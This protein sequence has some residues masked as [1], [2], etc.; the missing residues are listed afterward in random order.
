MHTLIIGNGIAGITT[1]LEIRKNSSSPITIISSESPLFFSRPAL[2]YVFMGISSLSDITPYAHDFFKKKNITLLQDEVISISALDQTV[3]CKNSNSISFDHLV[4]A[5]GS[6][7]IKPNWPGIDLDGVHYFY[8]LTDLLKLSHVKNKIKSAAIIGGG[9]IGVEIAE[10]LHSLRKPVHFLIKDNGFWKQ[11]LPDFESEM[12]NKHL[13]EKKINLHLNTE[14]SE[15]HGDPENHIRQISCPGNSTFQVDFAAIAIGVVPNISFTHNSGIHT[16]KGI[17]VNNLLQTNFKNIYAAGDCA[18]LQNPLPNRNSVE[19][20]WYI[21]RQMGES[22]GKTL[23]GNPTAFNQKIWFNAAKFFDF[24]FYQFG[25]I[26]ID[27]PNTLLFSNSRKTKSLRIAFNPMDDAIVG[28]LSM[29]I[30]LDQN[31]C[32]LWLREKYSLNDVISHLKPI[33]KKEKIESI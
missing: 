5:S 25:H 33:L 14:V 28:F 31:L 2:M 29:N 27:T 17:L 16:D 19:A 15:L 18:Q 6:I 23:T 12:T 8:H 7:P 1:A 24:E 11:G 26:P 30:R 32:E 22:L 3:L 10:M 4:I 20:T 9:L 13:K 21:A